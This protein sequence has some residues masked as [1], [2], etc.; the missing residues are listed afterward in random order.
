MSPPRVPYHGP[1]ITGA[2][3][4]D[5]FVRDLITLYYP[6]GDL[7]PDGPPVSE[8]HL[9]GSVA[10][11]PPVVTLD[12]IKM[13]CRIE[14]DQTVED[15]LLT[16]MEMAA[17]LTVQRYLRLEFDATVGENVKQAM[18]WLIA[19]MYRN[20]EAVIVGTISAALPLGYIAC[21][22]PERDYYGVY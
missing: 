5:N 3:D 1:V 4:R 11:L 8:H 20:R 9:S 6:Y 7:W 12:Q 10:A 14:T 21:L 15:E 22:F 16:G 2:Q 18:Y 19:H 13:H 17:R